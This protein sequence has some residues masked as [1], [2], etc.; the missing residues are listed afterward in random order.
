MA[1]TPLS[2]FQVMFRAIETQDAPL[3]AGGLY[4]FEPPEDAPADYLRTLANELRTAR[5]IPAPWNK[6][7]GRGVLPLLNDAPHV[8]LEY[9]IRHSALPQP[10]GERELGE[11]ISRIHSHPLDM[12]RPL[13]E[14]HLIDGLYG[15]RFVL[16]VKIH[17]ILLEGASA[18]TVLLRGLTDDPFQRGLSPVWGV[19]GGHANAGLSFDLG[20]LPRLAGGTVQTA[21]SFARTVAERD[22]DQALPF[23]CP[24]TMLDGAFGHHR[25]VATQIYQSERVE[26]VLSLSG[27]TQTELVQYLVGSALR[28]FLKEFNALP[29]QGL[30]AAIPIWN[31]E[32]EQPTLTMAKLGTE[33]A[34]P[35]RRLDLIRRSY[36]KAEEFAANVTGD[37]SIPYAMGLM[38]PVVASRLRRALLPER[39][40][41]N[42]FISCQEGPREPLYFNGAK[43]DALYPILP[44]WQGNG[45]SVSSAWLESGLNVSLAGARDKVPHLQRLAVYMGE[46]LERLE[47]ALSAKE[48]AA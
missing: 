40:L 23:V 44:L 18:L 16:Y 17:Q 5:D 36:K 10:G 48:T 7:L 24:R 26:R 47:E 19:A 33:I 13:W 45:L 25:R 21:L 11:L 3:H 15:G 6:V 22:D 41:W 12:R 29:D 30:T 37:A 34:D 27:I 46:A 35:L 4:I 42:V 39:T 9:H 31:E 1:T 2:P 28:R 32:A 20:T 38:G 8:D 43:L 14:C